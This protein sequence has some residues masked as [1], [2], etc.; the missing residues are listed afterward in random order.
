MLLFFTIS[1]RVFMHEY[2]LLVHIHTRVYVSTKHSS[3]YSSAN[4]NFGKSIICDTSNEYTR[5]GIRAHLYFQPIL[6]KIFPSSI[7]SLHRSL[8][9]VV[10]PKNAKM[11]LIV[12][13]ISP[14]YG[15]RR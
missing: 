10:I 6:L 7:Q 9:P 4:S 2:S 14:F 8:P 3:M 1:T 5:V 12:F 15:Q 13:T 11:L